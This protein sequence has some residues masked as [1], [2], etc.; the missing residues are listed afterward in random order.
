MMCLPVQ[1][2][3]WQQ[4]SVLWLRVRFTDIRFVHFVWIGAAKTLLSVAFVTIGVDVLGLSGFLTSAI[5]IPAIF[6]VSWLLTRRYL[7]K[8]EA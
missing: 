6:I 1:V 4:Q 8:E 3:S 5:S 2:P 7:L